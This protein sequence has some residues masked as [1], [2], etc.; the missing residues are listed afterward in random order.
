MVPYATEE[1]PPGSRSRR[2]PAAV[3]DDPQAASK[4]KASTP[5]SSSSSGKL[6]RLVRR[7]ESKRD[8]SVILP[9]PPRGPNGISR[10]SEAAQRPQESSDND[11]STYYGQLK[12]FESVFEGSSASAS[13]EIH[14]I[15]LRIKGRKH[16]PAGGSLIEAMMGIVP[17]RHGMEPQ[18]M[19]S[20]VVAGFLTEGPA[21]K[22]SDKLLI[23]D[24]IR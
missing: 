23:G 8:R 1:P 13:N 4:K 15:G 22:I 6:S 17:V 12:T 18:H 11:S 21:I 20:V 2:E 5:A 10:I 16:A 7:R 14:E 24:V 9:G 3:Q 19:N